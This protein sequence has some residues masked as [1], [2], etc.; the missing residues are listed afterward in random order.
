M[1]SLA[2]QDTTLDEAS[3]TYEYIDSV[4]QDCPDDKITQRTWIVS[5]D[6]VATDS[7]VQMITQIYD[8][9][10]SIS[11]PD[12]LVLDGECFDELDIIGLDT[13]T[14]PCQVVIDSVDVSVDSLLCGRAIV[15]RTVVFTDE[16][17][18]SSISFTQYIEVNDLPTIDLSNIDI[19]GD[20]GDSIGR[21]SFN[22]SCIATP[23]TFEW[24]NGSADTTISNL[25]VGDYTLTVT[26]EIGCENIFSFNV[27]MID[28]STVPFIISVTDRDSMPLELTSVRFLDE[29]G[30][31]IVNELSSE[32]QGVYTYRV[33]GDLSNLAHIC[34]VR[35]G[36]AIENVTVTDIIRGQRLILGLS[37][38]CSEDEIAGDVNLSGDVSGS[39]LVLMQRVILGFDQTFPDSIVW[40]FQTGNTTSVSNPENI[41]CIEV[42]QD[43]RDNRR[44]DLFGIKLGDYQ[45]ED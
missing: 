39:D 3:V 23:V 16:C 44:I 29:E 41:G 31:E 7:C 38:G 36:I 21:I 30:A 5:I 13:I 15:T 4:I 6:S 24:S 11:V 20:D 40:V 27:P 32:D 18:D 37:E 9:L 19:E 10:S 34:P 43:M 28:T 14:L 35:E 17:I 45:C 22:V 26:S 1:A 33:R 42:T 8:G 12:S 2:N 25:T